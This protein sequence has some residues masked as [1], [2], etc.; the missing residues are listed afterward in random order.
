MSLEEA[1]QGCR[2]SR[3]A[4]AGNYKQDG[5]GPHKTPC[6][7]GGAYGG[8]DA[9][10]YKPC[11]KNIRGFFSGGSIGQGVLYHLQYAVEVSL[12]THLLSLDINESLVDNGPGID[13]VVHGTE[14]K[15]R[16]ACHGCLIH[17]SKKMIHMTGLTCRTQEV[18]CH[19]R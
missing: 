19:L 15:S 2:K 14:F 7:D 11:S 3:C 5:E 17:D 18:W 9:Q 12:L 1:A 6:N 13:M 10:A 8:D 16:A 4:G